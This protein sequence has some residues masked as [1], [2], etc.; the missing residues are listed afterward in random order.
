M[1]PHPTS[2]GSPRCKLFLLIFLF[3]FLGSLLW[4]KTNDVTLPTAK[5]VPYYTYALQSPITFVP[6]YADLKF[7]Q[8]HSAS[9]PPRAHLNDIPLESKNVKECLH[10]LE[11][12]VLELCLHRDKKLE[13]PIKQAFSKMLIEEWWAKAQPFD[14]TQAEFTARL[15][16]CLFLAEPILAPTLYSAIKYKLNKRAI[17]PYIYALKYQQKN[18]IKFR[19]SVPGHFFWLECTDNW[20]GV[21]I[22]QLLI[23]S[24]AINAPE[25]NREIIDLSLPLLEDYLSSFNPDGTGSGGFRYWNYGFGQSYT[26]LAEL[27]IRATQ[28]QIDLYDHPKIPHIVAYPYHS[29]TNTPAS[30]F[31]LKQKVGYPNYADNPSKLSD[32]PNWSARIHSLR[33]SGI[34]E[35]PP[36]TDTE[37]LFALATLTPR[38]KKTSKMQAPI[39]TDPLRTFLPSTGMFIARDPASKLSVSA[40][41]GKNM[42]VGHHEHNHNDIGT[43]SIYID[44]ISMAGDPGDRNYFDRE[45]FGMRSYELPLVGAFTHPLPVVN[46]YYQSRNKEAEATVLSTSLTPDEDSITYDLT[47]VYPSTALASMHRKITLT[48]NPPEVTILDSFSASSPIHFAT[49]VIGKEKTPLKLQIEASGSITPNLEKFASYIPKDDSFV[50][51]KLELT[52]PATSGWIKQKFSLQ[53]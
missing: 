3:T 1:I 21:C 51:T 32:A 8:G 15:A 29:S 25:K 22:S 36:S 2:R 37:P 19:G 50:L 6:N 12:A 16:V 49:I 26:L 24:L 7:W 35:M 39:Q 5:P 45:A 38:T 46:S 42:G 52:Q 53:K 34:P 27:L 18:H 48:R 14:L 44:G 40:N 20:K 33:F 4:F 23:A 28:G 11:W 47:S 13:T 43:Y 30:E 31:G 41:G 17:D 9:F 10:F